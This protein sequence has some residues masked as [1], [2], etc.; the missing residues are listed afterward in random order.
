MPDTSGDSN[1]LNDGRRVKRGK[2][3][4]TPER[5][6]RLVRPIRFNRQ[7]RNAMKSTL[8]AFAL[9]AG[10]MS[11]MTGAAHA[12]VTSA[13]ANAQNGQAAPVQAYMGK[14]RAEV[15]RELV[16][17]QGDGEL[18]AVQTLFHGS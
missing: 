17:A 4:S 3:T 2:T 8:V 7:R 12:A 13:S 18:A 9:I 6:G 1:A 16:Q 14:T 11:A 5:N 15:K 10:A